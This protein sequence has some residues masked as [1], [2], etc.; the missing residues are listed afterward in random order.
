MLENAGNG[1]SKLVDLKIFWGSMLPGPPRG[2]GLRCLLPQPSTLL[3]LPFAVT[4]FSV[5]NILVK[6]SKQI[7]RRNMFVAAIFLRAK[8][9]FVTMEPSFHTAK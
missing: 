2:S 6:T 4:Y 7:G 9:R 1:I 8:R 5:K 3:S